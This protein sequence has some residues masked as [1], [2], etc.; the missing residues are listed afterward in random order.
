VA[1][2]QRA[3]YPDT[4]WLNELPRYIEHAKELTGRGTEIVLNRTDSSLDV[5]DH[6]TRSAW[7]GAPVMYFFPVTGEVCIF[8]RST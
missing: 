4:A 6:C 8:D 7:R 5:L 3:F 2:D 1:V